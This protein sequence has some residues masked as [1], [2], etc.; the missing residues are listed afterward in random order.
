MLDARRTK[1]KPAQASLVLMEH[2]AYTVESG[3]KGSL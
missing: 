2:M 3:L 1:V